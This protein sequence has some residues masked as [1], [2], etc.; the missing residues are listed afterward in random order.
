MPVFRLS[1]SHIFPEKAFFS[2]VTF[3]FRRGVEHTANRQTIKKQQRSLEASLFV[4]YWLFSVRSGM[5]QTKFHQ[6]NHLMKFRRFYLLSE[7]LAG[8]SPLQQGEPD[9]QR[10]PGLQGVSTTFFSEETGAT[11]AGAG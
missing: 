9:A 1:L 10:V 6:V 4:N 7:A 2:A 11:F 3:T 5:K 8:V